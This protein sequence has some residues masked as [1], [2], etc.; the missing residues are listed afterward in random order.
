MRWQL[1][2]LEIN[3]SSKI[4]LGH[5]RKMEKNTI[6][7]SSHAQSFRELEPNRPCKLTHWKFRMLGPNNHSKLQHRQVRKLDPDNLSEHA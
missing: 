3:N 5:F 1:H 6:L 4:T 2:K 7:Q